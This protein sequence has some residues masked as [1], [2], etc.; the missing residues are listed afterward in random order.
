M[1]PNAENDLQ[2]LSMAS[3]LDTFRESE[4]VNEQ[5]LADGGRIEFKTD[6]T[7]LFDFALEEAAA[8]GWEVLSL[9]RDLHRDPVMNEGNIMTEYE[10]RFSSLGNPIC[11]IILRP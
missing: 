7:V 6:N 5:V 8:A 3:V 11:K 2:N 10:E 9:T 4:L 1:E